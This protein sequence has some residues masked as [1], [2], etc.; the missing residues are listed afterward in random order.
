MTVRRK[1]TSNSR[2][3]EVKTRPKSLGKWLCLGKMFMG[4][5]EV[6]SA[7]SMLGSNGHSFKLLDYVYRYIPDFLDVG[8]W[9][10]LIMSRGSF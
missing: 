3:S 1:Q 5:Q 4:V 2:H 7:Y 8:N 10:E 6:P 9:K